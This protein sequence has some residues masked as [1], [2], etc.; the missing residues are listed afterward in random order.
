MKA[1]H[2]LVLLAMTG[3]P[4]PTYSDPRIIGGK[5]AAENQFPYQISLQVNGEHIC[6]GSIIDE[7]HVLTAAHCVF[8]RDKHVYPPQMM[9]VV[10]GS[11]YWRSLNR[12]QVKNI[13]THDQYKEILKKAV[14][15]IS[16][17][18]V[19]TPFTTSNSVRPI[20][21]RNIPVPTTDASNCVVSG[22]GLTRENGQPSARLRYVEI[23]I[24]ER[25]SCS[26]PYGGIPDGTVCAGDYSYNKDSCQGDSGG[27]LVCNGSLTGLVSYG[28]G[29][30]RL[31]FAGIY[32]DVN[33]YL[34][35]IRRE[36]ERSSS[37]LHLPSLW[38]LLIVISTVLFC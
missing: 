12:H 36:I 7:R 10:A 9:E 33:Y 22:W 23:M 21:L 14:N 4:V 29:C 11:L 38:I 25:T 37:K 26:I 16:L 19:S 24:M 8:D 2:L 31:G 20:A 27:P 28:Y 13:F 3:A 6:G 18:R 32:T 30:A 5:V 35:W 15:D 17:I 1:V 34:P